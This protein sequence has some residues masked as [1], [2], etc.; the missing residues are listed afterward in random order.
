M[1]ATNRGSK[2]IANDL[3]PTPKGTVNSMLNLIDW[4][5]VKS[6]LE[7]C[8]GNG[9]IYERVKELSP[10]PPTDLDYCEI[11]MGIDYLTFIPQNKYDLIVT[12]PP[13]SLAK[14]FLEK[15]LKESGCVC[16]LLR[17]NFLGGQK[18]KKELWDIVG[19]PNKLLI[20]SKRPSFTGKGTDATEY[21]WM[22]WDKNNIIKL[23]DGIHI[24]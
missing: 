10:L 15:S 17:L 21:C 14:E 9:D 23:N 18:R 1:S 20:L 2:R 19:T 6:F 16:Y 24:F 3:Y 7:P 12:N 8:Y 22:C 5:N 11:A 4:T 13:F